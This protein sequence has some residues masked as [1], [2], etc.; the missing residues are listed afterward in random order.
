MT[1]SFLVMVLILSLCAWGE[2]LAQ[3][4]APAP[5]APPLVHR[6]D[7]DLA[8]IIAPDTTLPIV[9]VA[10]SYH[11]GVAN[12]DPGQ[13]EFSHLFEHLMFMGSRHIPRGEHMRRIQAAGGRAD[14]STDFDR[15]VYYEQVPAN[16]L[17]ILLWLESDRM[18]FM[19]G[20]VTQEA[21]DLQ[22]SIVQNEHRQR[23][24][25]RPYGMMFWKALSTLYPPGHPYALPTDSW[26]A[27]LD[28]ATLDDVKSFFNRFYGPNNATIAIVG[29]VDA[30]TVVQMVAR[31]FGDIPP[32][33]PVERPRARPLR[34]PEDRFVVL[35]DDVEIPALL[36][37]W[38]S[39]PQFSAGDAE[40]DVLARILGGGTASRLYHRLVEQD[41][42]AQSVTAS[43]ESW[44]L[45]GQFMIEVRGLPGHD[46]S[47]I[48]N[49]VDEEITKLA[50]TA[51]PTEREVARAVNQI[52][53]DIAQ[54]HGSRLQRAIDL[55]KHYIFTGDANYEIE[56]FARY[57]GVTP[58][59]VQQLAQHYLL[60]GG[61]VLSDVPEGRTAMQ[62]GR[63]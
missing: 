3:S 62:A 58:A 29:D 40:L 12:E 44:A 60:A 17:E 10:V 59:A 34:L 47:Q 50:G 61:V 42:I 37:M 14:A 56:E 6:L 53:R 25:N 45:A 1:S 4:Q 38:P 41:R 63:P 57:Q 49:V 13:T 24:V 23:R 5:W 43:H 55:T 54:R 11:V 2:A 35:E 31:Y 28:S 36:L 20:S 7:N 21:L 51:P 32:T 26:M 46:L 15:T 9:A 19:S 48:P 27:D 16:D 8:V 39:V 30:A 52:E 22:R 33:P 18:G